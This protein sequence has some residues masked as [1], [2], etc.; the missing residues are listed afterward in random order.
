MQLEQGAAC[1]QKPEHTSN[2]KEVVFEIQMAQHLHQKVWPN[3]TKAKQCIVVWH[4]AIAISAA[5]H[6]GL[7]VSTMQRTSTQRRSSTSRQLNSQLK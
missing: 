3:S 6:L 7:T 1:H 2:K 4:G 5:T